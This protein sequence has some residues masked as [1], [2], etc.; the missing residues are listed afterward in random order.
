MYQGFY[1]SNR[2]LNNLKATFFRNSKKL[3]KFVIKHAHCAEGNY[4]IILLYVLA[5]K[6]LKKNGIGKIELDDLDLQ[7]NL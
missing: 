6:V 2:F 4:Q 3:V 7:F 5:F 1:K